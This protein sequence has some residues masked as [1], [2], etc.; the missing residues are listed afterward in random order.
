[1]WYAEDGIHIASGDA[2]RYLFY[3]KVVSWH[4]AAERIGQLLEQG[5]YATNV[6]LAE[7]PGHERME[8]AKSLWYLHGDLSDEAKE[9]G[10]LSSLVDYRSG[11]FPDAT[12]RLEALQD[13]AFSRRS[14]TNL[15]LLRCLF[16]GSEPDALT[17]I[18][19]RKYGRD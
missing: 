10:Y 6:E 4:E 2:S 7:A 18:S 1:M 12:A 19:C 5:E 11:G 8:L 14:G 3:A 9:Q 15:R 16:P 17:S 13:S